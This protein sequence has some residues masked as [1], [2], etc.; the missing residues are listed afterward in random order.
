MLEQVF[1]Q[2]DSIH[3]FSCILHEP[4]DAAKIAELVQNF[5]GE[6]GVPSAKAGHSAL[7][8]EEMAWNIFQHGFHADKRRHTV[9]LSMVVKEKDILLRIKDDCIPFDPVEF[10]QMTGTD[11]GNIGIRLVTA[12]ASQVSYQNLM[13]LNVLTIRM[14]KMAE[15]R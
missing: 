6:Y 8:F 15:K 5:C 14:E 10:S 9:N 7:C 1:D 11:A 13:G 2:S 12:L 3:R 4:D